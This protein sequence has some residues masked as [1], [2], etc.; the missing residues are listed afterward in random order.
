MAALFS[1]WPT[2]CRLRFFLFLTRQKLS[3]TFHNY[4]CTYSMKPIKHLLTSK[5]EQICVCT[6][7]SHCILHKCPFQVEVSSGAAN[8]QCLLL[9]LWIHIHSSFTGM[10]HNCVYCV[11]TQSHNKFNF[12]FPRLSREQNPAL[13]PAELKLLSDYT[14]AGGYPCHIFQTHFKRPEWALCLFPRRGN[15]RANPE[16]QVWTRTSISARAAV[17]H[18]TLGEKPHWK[19]NSYCNV[20]SLTLGF[21]SF[22]QT[23]CFLADSLLWA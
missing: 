5:W 20:C 19:H 21:H 7:T 22:C 16:F 18:L 3:V 4:S 13:P 23:P 10:L 15:R 12:V 1:T 6:S 14:N 17:R 2:F 8:Q 9:H 11:A